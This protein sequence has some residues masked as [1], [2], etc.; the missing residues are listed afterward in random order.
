MKT[1]L[2]FL[3][4]GVLSLTY[5]FIN[6]LIFQQDMQKN[7]KELASIIY[8]IIVGSILSMISLFFLFRKTEIKPTNGR[9]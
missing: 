7:K 5:A 8:M 9:S 3:A 4:L 6:G 1:F 2:L